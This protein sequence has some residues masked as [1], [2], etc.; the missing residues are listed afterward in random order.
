MAPPAVGLQVG[1]VDGHHLSFHY[2]VFEEPSEEAVEDLEVGPFSQAVP[3]VSEEAV[4]RRPLPES[5]GP[6]CLPV[7]LQPKG[8]SAVAGDA[9]E[10]LQ[11]LSLQHRHRVVGLPPRTLPVVEASK[12]AA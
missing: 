7:V 6:C 10:M 3:E 9:E 5:A 11:E 12:Q 8:E 1:A 2:S 4:A